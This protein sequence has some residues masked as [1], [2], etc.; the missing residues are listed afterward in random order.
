MITPAVSSLEHIGKIALI[1]KD[2]ND[3]VVGGFVLML[4]PVFQDDVISEYLIYAFAAK[5]HRDNCNS[6][7]HKYGQAFYNMSRELLM[8]L[9]VPLPPYNEM[10]RITEKLKV[11]LPFVSEYE[12]K[13]S[14]ISDLDG[15]F[16]DQ[17]KKTILQ[18][19][20]QG[21]LVPQDENDEPSSVLLERIRA[22]KDKLS[23]AGNIKRD[24]SESIIF[25]RNNSHYEKI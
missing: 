20:V 10:K 22:E 2:Y 12:K 13:E 18:M 21:K 9:P 7:T 15:S 19:A 5:H 11:I 8:N 23:A 25:R 3:T 6:I 14:D 24:K 16:P 4:L 1:D 17:L